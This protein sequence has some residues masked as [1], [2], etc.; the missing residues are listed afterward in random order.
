MLSSSSMESRKD[1]IQGALT[2]N[3]LAFATTLPVSHSYMIFERT[4]ILK[5]FKGAKFLFVYHVHKYSVIPF[6][7]NKVMIAIA[8][9]YLCFGG[10]SPLSYVKIMFC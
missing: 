1:F 10:D 9:I 2:W 6:E 3:I 7:R 4:T 8:L 5:T